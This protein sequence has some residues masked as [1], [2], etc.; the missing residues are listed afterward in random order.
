MKVL[1]LV[2]LICLLHLCDCCDR[3]SSFTGA[4]SICLCYVCVCAGFLVPSS[5]TKFLRFESCFAGYDIGK[6]ATSLTK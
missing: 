5:L 1:N 6:R 2:A 3:T 4:N